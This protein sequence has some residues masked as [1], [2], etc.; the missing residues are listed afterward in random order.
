MTGLEYPGWIFF[1]STGQVY[2]D[3]AAVVREEAF[4]ARGAGREPAGQNTQEVLHRHLKHTQDTQWHLF[5]NPAWTEESQ[6]TRFR[7]SNLM[8]VAFCKIKQ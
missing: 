7:S 5:H 1:L 3:V 2:E 4:G 8:R 6:I